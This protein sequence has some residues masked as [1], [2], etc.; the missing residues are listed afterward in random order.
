MHIFF[1]LI[2]F[3]TLFQVKRKKKHI[4][5]HTHKQT[6]CTFLV[7]KNVIYVCTPPILEIQQRDHTKIYQK[8]YH[9]GLSKKRK[10]YNY[11]EVYC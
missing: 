1:R 9:H 2:F 11:D 5:L 3:N 10:M 6:K 7:R 4:V 8:Y